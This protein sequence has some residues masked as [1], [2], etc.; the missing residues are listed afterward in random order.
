MVLILDQ[1]EQFD[2][3]RQGGHVMGRNQNRDEYVSG[4]RRKGMNVEVRHLEGTL[5][6]VTLVMETACSK[7]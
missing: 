6:L 4:L 1:R 5:S 2:R 7:P 3:R